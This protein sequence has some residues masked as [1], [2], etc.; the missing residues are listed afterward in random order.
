[1]QQK[2]G[3]IVYICSTECQLIVHKESLIVIK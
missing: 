1:M 2:F 3:L